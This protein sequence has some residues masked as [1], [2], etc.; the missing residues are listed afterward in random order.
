MMYNEHEKTDNTRKTEVAMHIP[1]IVSDWKILFK[2]EKFGKYVNDHTVV[3]C[4]DGYRL[5]G[6]T[7][8]DGK[9]SNERYF[10]NA[11]GASLDEPFIEDCKSVDTGT[12]AWAPCVIEKDNV[13]YMFYGPS[14]TKLAVS[15]DLKEWMGYEIK[16][17]GNPLFAVHRDHFVLKVG[18]E[19]LMYA[20][21]LYN[22]RGSISVMTSENLTD[23]NFCGYAL[24]SGKDA[25]LTPAWGAFESPFVVKRD[26]G[27]YLFVT[28]TNS[29]QETYNDTFVFYS[30]DAK[31]FGEYNGEKG[32]VLP[33]AKLKCHAGEV[34]EHD[35]KY[36]ITT[37]GWITREVP[38][39]GCVSIAE[40]EF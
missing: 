27:Y 2:P 36:Y 31:N 26:D 23:W 32:E 5:I 35:G 29:N 28:Y 38:H 40:L 3:K 37:C 10:V 15:I 13:Y 25:P 34:I 11:Y 21:G 24:T 12:L 30:A 4:K 18:D 7:G 6:I 8:F 39:A 20:A 22:G 19:Y 33:I 1:K 14:P 17:N 9:P 16:L